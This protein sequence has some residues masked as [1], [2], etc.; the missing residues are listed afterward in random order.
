MTSENECV[1]LQSE[2]FEH[3]NS[4]QCLNW[5]IKR[6]QSSIVR[7]G[8]KDFF[9]GARVLDLGCGLGDNSRYIAG[10]ASAVV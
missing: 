5:E 8:E 9:A 3:Y 1:P 4:N 2:Y 6:P 10:K 7:L